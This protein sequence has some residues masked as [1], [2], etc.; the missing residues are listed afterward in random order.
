M[1]GWEGGR[2]KRGGVAFGLRIVSARV[3]G[4][5][6]CIGYDQNWEVVCAGWRWGGGGGCRAVNEG[7]RA[8]SPV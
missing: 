8:Q 4:V 5:H 7:D 3:D 2:E 1:W 6:G